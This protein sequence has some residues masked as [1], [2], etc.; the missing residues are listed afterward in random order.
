[1]A[2]VPKETPKPL[3]KQ[4]FKKKPKP[5]PR[6]QQA[7]IDKSDYA[8]PAEKT[9]PKSKKRAKGKPLSQ[10]PMQLYLRGIDKDK[11]LITG[12]ADTIFAFN[13]FCEKEGLS[14]WEALE[15]LM[16]GLEPRPKITH[17]KE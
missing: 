16:R 6:A 5:T 2:I 17:P 8:H 9:K 12:P 10:L 1:M 7:A 3:V 14:K 11:T 15:L 13:S 4:E